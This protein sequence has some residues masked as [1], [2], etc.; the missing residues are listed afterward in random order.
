MRNIFGEGTGCLLAAFHA[1]LWGARRVVTEIRW[2]HPLAR[3]SHRLRSFGPPGRPAAPEARMSVAGGKLAS[4]SAPA[5]STARMRR[6]PKGR[7]RLG[8]IL[9][10]FL[11][12]TGSLNAAEPDYT[13]IDALFQKHCLDCHNAKDAEG[14]LILESYDL[15]MKG[16]ESGAVVLPGQSAESILV[17][18]V[19]GSFEKDGKR[20]IMPPGSKRKKLDSD[21]IALLKAWIDAGAKGPSGPRKPVELVTPKIPVKG[22][23]R[24]PISSLAFA[25][26]SGLIAVA[27]YGEVELREARSSR[28]NEAHSEKSEIRNPKSEIDQSLLTSAATKLRGHRGNANGVTFSTDGSQL[29]AAAGEPGLFGEVRQWSVADG[30]L[31]RVFEGHGDAIY[32]LA[33][34]PNG[35]ILVTGSYDQKIKL[36]D[37]ESGKELN[38]LSGHN[39][40]VFGLAFRPDGKILASASAD[41]TVKLWN[42]ESGKRT[43]TL[44]QPLKEQYTVAFSSDG[45]RLYAGGADSRIRIWQIS[46][47]AVETTNPMRDAHF[48]H[49][50]TILRMVFSPDGGTLLSCAD[51]RTVKLWSAADMKQKLVLGQQRDWAT[52]AAFLDDGRVTV[53]RMD[54]SLDVYD[55]RTGHALRATALKAEVK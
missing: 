42:V 4:A 46:E 43:D 50:G 31:V 45:K 8:A 11:V 28:G 1:P 21:E 12:I 6:A 33:L 2:V 35:K 30:K 16:G 3:I 55:T 38:T 26:R 10:A 52:A 40:A 51:D 25:S 22:E 18:S 54:G 7:M 49:E 53:G 9:F 47:S 32:S 5:G 17:K 48:A 44:S 15:L 37:V 23:P 19:E 29:F 27:R 39:G 34:S 13:R 24:R 36:W 41:R 20:R 14:Q